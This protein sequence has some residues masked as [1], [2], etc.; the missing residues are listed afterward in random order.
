MSR[1]LRVHAILLWRILFSSDNFFISKYIQQFPDHDPSDSHVRSACVD[2]EW[3]RKKAA[4]YSD[5]QPDRLQCLSTLSSLTKRERTRACE[6]E[7]NGLHLRDDREG[8]W[9]IRSG[10][11]SSTGSSPWGIKKM[12]DRE[13]F[14]QAE[15]GR[16]DS[17]LLII[18]A[19]GDNCRVVGPTLW[20]HVFPPRPSRCSS[21]QASLFFVFTLPP[22]DCASSDL[23]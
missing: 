5:S 8:K 13:Q 9:S 20:L 18:K 10:I 14:G 6:L 15:R 21:Q 23:Y 4:C 12:L 17:V 1:R 11:C 3:V 7:V 22:W 16:R 19:T 2:N